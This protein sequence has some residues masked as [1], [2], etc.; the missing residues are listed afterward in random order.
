MGSNYG[1]P[2]HTVLAYVLHI[3]LKIG[4]SQYTFRACV[5]SS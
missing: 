3:I 1:K 5:S 4:L 2:D